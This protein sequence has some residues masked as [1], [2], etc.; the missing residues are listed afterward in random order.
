VGA[1]I[2]NLKINLRAEI[3]PKQI[4]SIL[5]TD[6]SSIAYKIIFVFDYYRDAEE[7]DMPDQL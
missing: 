2:Y 7:S 3:E 6:V 4:A 1:Q 5:E